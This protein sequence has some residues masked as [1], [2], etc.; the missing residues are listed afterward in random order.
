[1]KHLTRSQTARG[2]DRSI[3]EKLRFYN[4]ADDDKE[5]SARL[6][7]RLKVLNDREGSRVAPPRYS[8]RILIPPD[9][10]ESEKFDNLIKDLPRVL[11]YPVT[12][13]DPMFGDKTE[14]P[15]DRTT[16]YF[17]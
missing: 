14:R 6:H 5:L 4:G 16:H 1:M 8:F 12:N 2:Q 9:P 7:H 17:I 3:Q 11:S 15:L 10:H 13:M